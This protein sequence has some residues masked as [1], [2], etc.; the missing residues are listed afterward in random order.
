MLIGFLCGFVAGAVF[1]AAALLVYAALK[2]ESKQQRESGW[3]PWE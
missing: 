3:Q 2:M 1:G